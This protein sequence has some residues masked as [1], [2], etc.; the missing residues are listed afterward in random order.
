MK[1]FP[2][3]GQNLTVDQAELID[4]EGNQAAVTQGL[5]PV[6]DL[7]RPVRL[8]ESATIVAEHRSIT[9]VTAPRSL[10]RAER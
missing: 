9:N 8:P 5:T 1:G 7:K 10:Y 2:P 3:G 4:D 6:K